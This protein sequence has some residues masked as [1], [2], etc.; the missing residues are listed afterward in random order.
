M[1]EQNSC[2]CHHNHH[3]H[4]MIWFLLFFCT[5]GTCSNKENEL[6]SQIGKLSGE[7][8]VLKAEVATLR[9]QVKQNENHP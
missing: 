4:F 9:S 8:T 2:K 1:S 7:V 5:V 6:Q 3:S